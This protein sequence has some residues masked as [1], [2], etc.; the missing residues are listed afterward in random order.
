MDNLFDSLSEDWVSQPGSQHSSP[1]VR[2]SPTSMIDGSQSRIPMPKSRTSS[3]THNIGGSVSERRASSRMSTGSQ[4]NVLKARTQSELNSSKRRTLD[5]Q[6][7]AQ[8]TMSSQIP[9]G[10]LASRDGNNDAAPQ[11]TVQ[12]RSLGSQKENL[13]ATPEWKKRL[14]KGGVGPAPQTDLF[15]PKPVGLEGMF[16]PPTVKSKTPQKSPGRK[17]RTTSEGKPSVG[18]SSVSRSSSQHVGKEKVAV[19]VPEGRN[20]KNQEKKSIAYLPNGSPSAHDN[21]EMSPA[22]SVGSKGYSLSDGFSPVYISKH[23]SSD[24]QVNY[25]A[26]DTS[27]RRLNSNMDRLKIERQRQASSRTAERHISHSATSASERTAIRDAVNEITS[28]SLPDD[29]SMGTDAFASNGGFVSVKRGGYSDDGSFQRRPLSPSSSMNG[30]DAPNVAQGEK[31]HDPKSAKGLSQ[32]EQDLNP[33]TPKTPPQPMQGAQSSPER[34]RSS[35]SPLKLFDKYDTFTN[36]RLIRRMSKF[37]ETLGQHEPD[38]DDTHNDCRTSSPST[39]SRS[40]LKSRSTSQRNVSRTTSRYSSFGEGNLDDYDFPLPLQEEPA[41]PHLPHPHP[42]SLDTANSTAH[43]SRRKAR[44]SSVTRTHS[45]FHHSGSDATGNRSSHQNHVPEAEQEESERELV[46]AETPQT[47][48]G[49]RI[50]SSP[51]KNHERKRRRTI[52]SSE[53]R[54]QG[55]L[56]AQSYASDANRI[57]STA[58]VGKK[59][60]DALYEKEQQ[61]A[62]PH[63]LAMRQMRRPRNPTPNHASSSAMNAPEDSILDF[64]NSF[65]EHKSSQSN[66]DIDA[67][68]QI[69]AGALATVAV[70]AAQNVTAKSRKASVNTADFFNEAQ[71]IMRL[72]RAERRPQSNQTTADASKVEPPIIHEESFL[73]E[74]TRDEFS[75]PPSREGGTLRDRRAPAQLNSRIVSQLRKFED[76]DDLGLALPSSIK[77]LRMSRSRSRSRTPSDISVPNLDQEGGRSVTSDPPNIRILE[78]HRHEQA[79]M[80]Q[81]HESQDHLNN[82][83]RQD[84]QTSFNSTKRSLPT[85]SSGSSHTRMIIAPDTVAHLLSD[86][87]AGMMFDRERQMWVK[88]KG[89]LNSNALDVNESKGDGSEDDLFGDIPDLSVDEMNELQMVKNAVSASNSIGSRATRVESQDY[90][91]PNPPIRNESD[92]RQRADGERPRTADGK[93]VGPAEDSSAPSKFTHFASSGPAPSTRATSWGDEQWSQKPQSQQAPN[94]PVVVENIGPPDSEEVEHEIS[95]LEGRAAKPPNRK[96]DLRRQARVV[97]VAFSSPLVDHMQS[98]DIHESW[99]QGERVESS[100]T[101]SRRHVQRTPISSM[102]KSIMSCSRRMSFGDRSLMGPP[103]SRLDENE[104]MSLVQYSAPPDRTFNPVMST[105]L[106]LTRSVLLPP[107]AGKCSSMGFSLSPLADFTVHQIDRPVDADPRLLPSRHIAHVENRLSLTAQG[108]VKHLTDIEPFE[109]Y[110]EYIRSA[111]LHDRSLTSLHM[112]DEFC[113]CLEELDISNNEVS[114]TEGIPSSVRLLNVRGNCLSNMSAWHHLQHLQ[115]LDIS[116]NNLTTLKG[117]HSLVHLRALKADCNQIQELR[118]LEELDGLLSLSLRGNQVREVNFHEYY[119]Y[120]AH[121]QKPRTY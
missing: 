23:E 91:A 40:L 77:E 104:E 114:S 90:A 68:T 13:Q 22:G 30:L 1:A 78:R 60:K 108:L 110:W 64:R 69:V 113:G 29:L 24:G 63:V 102:R 95:I 121:F 62:D 70:N 48:N 44:R 9:G 21:K 49:K 32:A 57:T 74:S 85:G 100:D 105:P 79:D 75:R 14:V 38:F 87:M 7:K 12:Y 59:R 82:R 89:S 101:P 83:P 41:L 42:G 115:Y 45:K 46:Y 92:A 34:P 118:G 55:V 33:P 94:L 116:G 19:V 17:L 80:I 31:L 72:I 27:M 111:D 35:G 39:G 71:Q 47:L 67:P 26:I 10:T 3:A 99:D 4:K 28:Q 5:G 25:A 56:A 119:L 93:T 2:D 11:G 66:A 61:A 84:S 109:P 86:Q 18:Q 120:V 76:E 52:R 107:T 81:P 6:K 58:L 53:E 73:A 8:G 20:Q 37:E 36:D 15:S 98:P 106:P 96:G 88:N 50:H 97:T 43:G 51:E 103:M 65:R 54:L 117:L 16:R 112:L